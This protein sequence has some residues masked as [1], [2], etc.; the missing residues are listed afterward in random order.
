MQSSGQCCA[1]GSPG[2]YATSCIIGGASHGR[3][4][5]LLMALL[6]MSWASAQHAIW[7][8]L[9]IDEALLVLIH[10]LNNQPADSAL[11]SDKYLV[12]TSS[13]TMYSLLIPSSICARQTEMLLR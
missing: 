4:E 13:L 1:L 8:Y 7:L 3:L 9:C 6:H 10:T 2:I 11:I 12:W 5:A